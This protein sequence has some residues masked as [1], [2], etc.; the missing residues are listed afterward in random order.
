MSRRTLHYTGA[1]QHF[2][3]NLLAQG[4]TDTAWAIKSH[5]LELCEFGQQFVQ[6]EKKGDTPNLFLSPC[7]AAPADEVTV[8]FTLE[9]LILEK[10]VIVVSIE[11]HLK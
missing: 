11:E 9:V 5:L 8:G 6:L 7:N 3:Q 1:C 4:R 2:M 10:G